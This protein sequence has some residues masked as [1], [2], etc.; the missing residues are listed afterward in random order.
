MLKKIFATR[1]QNYLSLLFKI[2]VCDDDEEEEL[3]TRIEY[4]NQNSDMT[5][6]DCTQPVEDCVTDFLTSLT[7]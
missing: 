7:R 1:R 2:V 5:P 6:E 4:Y 3:E